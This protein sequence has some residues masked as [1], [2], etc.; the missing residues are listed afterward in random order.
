MITIIMII[1]IIT[2]TIIII[3]IKGCC[4]QI[5]QNTREDYNYKAGNLHRYVVVNFLSNSKLCMWENTGHHKYFA[6]ICNNM[7]AYPD[8]GVSRTLEIAETV[9]QN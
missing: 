5:K 1:I 3:I 2:I 7:T 8:T 4:I 6:H 9:Q